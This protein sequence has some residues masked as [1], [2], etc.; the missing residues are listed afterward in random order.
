L[1]L[2]RQRKAAKESW[3]QKIVCLCNAFFFGGIATKKK[4]WQKRNG[5]LQ[6][7]AACTAPLR[8]GRSLLKKRRK[9]I[10]Q[11]ECEHSAQ[12]FDKSKFEHSKGEEK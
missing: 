6:A 12:P 7:C 1:R 2:F 11:S 8:V 10:A 3:Y 5:V 4:A 9:T